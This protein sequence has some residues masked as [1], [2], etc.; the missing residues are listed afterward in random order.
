M[1]GLNDPARRH[2]LAAIAARSTRPARNLSLRIRQSRQRS[3]ISSL[4]RGAPR[5]R[6]RTNAVRR[7]ATH[8]RL[9]RHPTRRPGRPRAAPPNAPAAPHAP[10]TNPRPTASA[11]GAHNAPHVVELRTSHHVLTQGLRPTHLD[12]HRVVAAMQRE[13][14]RTHSR[15]GGR[16]QRIPVG[17]HA[18]SHARPGDEVAAVTVGSTHRATAGARPTRLKTVT[19][20]DTPDDHRHRLR[21]STIRPQPAC[22]GRRPLAPAKRPTQRPHRRNLVLANHSPKRCPIRAR[23]SEVL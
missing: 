21:P 8:W 22:L 3:L 17:P 20:P 2:R 9:H 4:E 1:N 7:R 11:P 15:S 19:S 6:F 14:V 5:V 23:R 10:A 16:R 12:T 13:H 18:E